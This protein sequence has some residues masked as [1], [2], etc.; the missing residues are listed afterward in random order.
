MPQTMK[1]EIYFCQHLY[2]VVLKE[3]ENVHR[4]P[5]VQ[6]IRRRQPSAVLREGRH[7]NGRISLAVVSRE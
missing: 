4:E 6:M 7:Q 2:L 1:L 5:K 3:V